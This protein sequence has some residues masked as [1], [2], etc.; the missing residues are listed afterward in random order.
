MADLVS[1]LSNTGQELGALVAVSEGEDRVRYV[2]I[3]FELEDLA[4]LWQALKPEIEG[5]RSLSHS[6]S[7]VCEG[8]NSWD[9]YLLL[10][11]YDSTLVLDEIPDGNS[12]IQI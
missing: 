4:R 5:R 6:T 12:E 8:N 11:H 10:H 2:N 3:N 7:V 1:L 9:D